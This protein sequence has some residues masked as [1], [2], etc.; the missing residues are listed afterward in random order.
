M[1]ILTAEAL[2]TFA[3]FTLNRAAI[4]S[5]AVAVWSLAP[6]SPP[7]VQRIIK[8]AR[9]AFEFGSQAAL[10]CWKACSGITHNQP[11]GRL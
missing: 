3:P 6:A 9:D 1:L 7:G 11:S 10:T 5:G 2:H 4:K 8:E